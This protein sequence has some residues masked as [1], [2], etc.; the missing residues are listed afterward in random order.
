MNSGMKILL[1]LPNYFIMSYSYFIEKPVP[2][3]CFRSYIVR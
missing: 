3:D 2:Y 1:P